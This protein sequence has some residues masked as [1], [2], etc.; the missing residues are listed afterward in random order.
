MRSSSLDPPSFLRSR[1][2]SDRPSAPAH[3]LGS[4]AI[5]ASINACSVCFFLGAGALSLPGAPG[6]VDA[7]IDLPLPPDIVA[8]LRLSPLRAAYWLGPYL[9]AHRGWVRSPLLPPARW[10]AL[11]FVGLPLRGCGP[12]H[13]CWPISDRELRR[14]PRTRAR[15]A[16]DYAAGDPPHFLAGLLTGFAL[17]LVAVPS[18]NT[19]RSIFIAGQ[20]PVSSPRSLHS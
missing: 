10:S 3:Q 20:H 2:T 9:G 1:L 18:A 6:V 4:A 14:R 7:M 13:R 15:R 5:S 19:D 16:A 11:V 17:A 12:W 8:E